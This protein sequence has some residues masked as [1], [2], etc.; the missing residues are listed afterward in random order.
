[1]SESSESS[2][3]CFKCGKQ[4]DDR[5]SGCKEAYYCSRDCS[6]WN[7]KVGGHK[8]LCRGPPLQRRMH[9]ILRELFVAEWEW[10]KAGECEFW[11]WSPDD[12]NDHPAPL[13]HL[14]V[15]GQVAMVLAR[16]NPCVLLLSYS[17]P[18]FGK[19]YH[20]KILF[21]WY[22]THQDFLN[23]QGFEIEFI[24]HGV[25]LW[26]EPCQCV[27][28]G[29]RCGNLRDFAQGG[30]GGAALAKDMRS[31]KIELVNKVFHTRRP[32]KV[33]AEW[34]EE[35][36]VTVKDLLECYSFVRDGD[37]EVEEAGRRGSVQYLFQFP[38][39]VFGGDMDDYCCSPCFNSK[40]IVDPNDAVSLGN[41]FRKARETMASIGFFIVM[42]IRDLEDWP[43]LQ[44]AKLWLAIA[45]GSIQSLEAWI[46]V[47]E[48][49]FSIRLNNDSDRRE[50]ILEI[51]RE[52]PLFVD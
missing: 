45:D 37:R 18:L 4:A 10:L 20:D 36:K 17:F 21:P 19:E 41:H 24:S 30:A 34:K 29:E 9:I 26:N 28:N 5:C 47:G 40:C 39:Q 44:I 48:A 6:L 15:S 7:W 52:L 13:N 35:D 42:D 31:P 32:Q 49:P 2:H 43:N 46:Y 51:A 25:H 38:N 50:R 12:D 23:E 1:M 8:A 33:S 11:S 27:V 14:F 3:R 16:V 22:E